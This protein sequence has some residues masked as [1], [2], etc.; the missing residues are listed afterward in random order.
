MSRL[1]AIVGAVL[2]LSTPV[3]LTSG[4]WYV[5]VV[6]HDGFAP[7]DYCIEVNQYPYFDPGSVQLFITNGWTDVPP[8]ERYMD[9]TLIGPDYLRYQIEYSDTLTDDPASWRP[10]TD[11]VSGQPIS[12][13]PGSTMYTYH[14]A[15]LMSGNPPGL[16][17]MRFYRVRV[18]P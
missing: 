10:F 7:T 12:F 4:D 18:V 6:N 5:A 17:R 11:L 2:L 13:G 16:V 1:A 9:L 15:P 14:D 8:P 3:P